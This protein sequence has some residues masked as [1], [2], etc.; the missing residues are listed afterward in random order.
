MIKDTVSR[1][2]VEKIIWIDTKMV[3][4]HVLTK[5]SALTEL[6]EE[7]FEKGVLNS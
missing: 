6:I 5:E 7:V 3:I 1:G 2:E 4:P